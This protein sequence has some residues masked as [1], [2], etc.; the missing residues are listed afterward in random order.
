MRRE[1]SLSRVNQLC[2][3]DEHYYWYLPLQ[4]LRK[5]LRLS[6]TLGSGKSHTKLSLCGI[7]SIGRSC[8]SS[9]PHQP[10]TA[11]SRS[12][13]RFWAQERIRISCAEATVSWT[14]T[15]FCARS[16]RIVRG[17]WSW[18]SPVRYSDNSHSTPDFLKAPRTNSGVSTQWT[19]GPKR[20]PPLCA[21]CVHGQLSILAACWSWAT[22]RA[23]G[24]PAV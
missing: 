22:L 8:S 9:L 10:K 16:S 3:H 5:G 2:Q 21:R 12:L 17:F 15:A 13:S 20:S 7:A 23:G 14:A 19:G 1:S 11:D 18:K 24:S 4:L 6:M